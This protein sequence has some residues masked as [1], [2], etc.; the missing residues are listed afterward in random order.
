[1]GI[2]ENIIIEP[3]FDNITADNRS[4]YVAH[5]Y[6]YAGH[7]ALVFNSQSFELKAGQCMV[8]VTNRL[9]ESVTPSSDCIAKVI[10]I[11]MGFLGQCTPKSNF[12]VVGTC[13]LF[14]NPIYDLTPEESVDCRKNF[15]A[16]ERKFNNKSHHFYDDVMVSSTQLLFLDLFEFQVRIYGEQQV[17]LQSAM[18]MSK[19]LGMLETGIYRQHR[20]VAYYASELCVVPKYL[21]QVS[22]SVSGF[23]ANYWIDRFTIQ[24]I[25]RNLRDK[26]KTYQE[27][28]DIFNFSSLSYFS[29]YVQRILGASLTDLRN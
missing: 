18:I 11:K 5:V 29:R 25:R 1:M 19:F 9:L 15:E 12:G 6:C 27:I 8:I 14:A 7:C 3:H 28:A 16:F 26:T 17:P 24:D 22:K 10:Y 21:S 2:S 13:R 23:S 4:D 20:E